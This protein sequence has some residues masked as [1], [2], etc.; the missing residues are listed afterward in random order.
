MGFDKDLC[1]WSYKYGHAKPS[2]FLFQILLDKLK[3]KYNISA[4]EVLY[5]GNDM[6][7]DIFTASSAG[8]KTALF[9]GDIRSLRLRNKNEQCIGLTS[10]MIIT[11]LLQIKDLFKRR[12]PTK[13]DGNNES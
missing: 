6:L 1:I 4:D 5:V 10:D 2:E 11:D 13:L 8:C 3:K 9:G 12:L 7:N